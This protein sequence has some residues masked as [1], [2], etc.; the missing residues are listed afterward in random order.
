MSS[1]TLL[2]RVKHGD[3]RGVVP[4]LSMP[5][6]PEGNISFF[7]NTRSIMLFISTPSW[8]LTT[9]V[10]LCKLLYFMYILPTHSPLLHYSSSI[11]TLS[12]NLKSTSYTGSHRIIELTHPKSII[13]LC[14]T[15]LNRTAISSL[16]FPSP[17][18][19][20]WYYLLHTMILLHLLSILPPS[21]QSIQ[22][23]PF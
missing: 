9:T 20:Q 22:S 17:A 1:P 6:H 13:T 5:S 4:F 15:S 16:A 8:P 21:R 10:Y 2:Y 14:H 11:I 23:F 3:L 7:T 18:Q 12:W 19:R